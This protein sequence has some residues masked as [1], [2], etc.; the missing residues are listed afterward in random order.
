MSPRY[1]L[2]NLASSGPLVGPHGNCFSGGGWLAPALSNACLVI[3]PTDPSGFKPLLVWNW[4]IALIVFRSVKPFSL[5]PTL[6]TWF[7]DCCTQRTYAGSH[8]SCLHPL[9]VVFPDTG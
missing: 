7:N 8:R 2:R 9:P 3:G 5:S 1:L 6:N 4:R